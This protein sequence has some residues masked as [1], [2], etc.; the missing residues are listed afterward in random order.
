MP[1]GGGVDAGACH[2]L[3]H[4]RGNRQRMRIPIAAAVLKLRE[5]ELDRPLLA[6][7]GG[8]GIRWQQFRGNQTLKDGTDKLS[9]CHVSNYPAL[10]LSHQWIAYF[11]K[12]PLP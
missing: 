11:Q 9:S 5:H 12:F 10:S 8:A 6:R 1:R 4:E 2:E 7:N 3:F